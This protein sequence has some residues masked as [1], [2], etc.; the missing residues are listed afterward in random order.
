VW[1]GIC[2]KRMSRWT[3]KRKKVKERG[4]QNDKYCLTNTATTDPWHVSFQT[5]LT[6]KSTFCI[7]GGT[8]LS[9]W[10]VKQLLYLP[11]LLIQ[12]NISFCLNANGKEKH[13]KNI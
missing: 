2:E 1:D 5:L 8:S 9:S 12:L 13:K 3:Q 7:W 6:H 11:Q 10:G 4:R